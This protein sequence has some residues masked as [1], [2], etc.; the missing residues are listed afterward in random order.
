M[1]ATDGLS[2][3]R[4]FQRKDRY[5]KAFGKAL[6]VLGIAPFVSGIVTLFGTS[7]K[8]AIISVVILIVG[9]SIGFILILSVQ[10]KYNKGVF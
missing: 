7:D 3:N 8:I 2:L 10:K 4:A 6:I 5:G 9:L 1:T